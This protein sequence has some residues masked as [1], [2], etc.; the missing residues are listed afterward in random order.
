MGKDYPDYTKGVNVKVE[1][2][3][4]EVGPTNVIRYQAVPEDI[5]EGKRGPILGD[6]KGRPIVL[7]HEKDRTVETPA[8]K[9][10]R[11]KGHATDE[12]PVTLTLAEFIPRPK[13]GVLEK[14]SQT[15]TDS[16]ATIASRVVTSAKT[17]QLSKIMVSA[18][19]AAWVKF[20]WADSDISAERLLDDKTILVEHFPWDYHTMVGD[21][22]KKFEVQ[23]KYESEGGK[24]N[25][26]IVGE[27]V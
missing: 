23:A 2:P 24:V 13:G 10:V 22:T 4:V 18:E 5:G 12:V 11:I 21:G 25:V 17:F 26:E 20:L 19:K 16:Y 14:G 3:E 27:E 6:K 15:T 9:F 7:Q 8:G 1:I